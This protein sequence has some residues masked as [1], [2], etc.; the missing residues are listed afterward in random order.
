VPTYLPWLE[1]GEAVPSP[2][3]RKVVTEAASYAI[4]EWRSPRST[5]DSVPSYRVRLIRTTE[6]VFGGSA[7]PVKTPIEDWDPGE[8]YDGGQPG[9]ASVYWVIPNVIGCST[10]A[11][12]FSA[13]NMARK[14]TRQEIR[15]IAES[16]RPAG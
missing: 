5:N 3:S 4:L 1:P 16:V 12:W 11:V 14:R 6:Y 9:E 15:R 8:L 7:I 10:V 13:T 2:L